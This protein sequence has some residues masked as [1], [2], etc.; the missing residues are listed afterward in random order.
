MIASLAMLMVSCKEQ[1]QPVVDVLPLPQSVELSEGSFNATCAAV[2]YDAKLDEA[3]AVAVADFAAQLSTVTGH[4]RSAKAV[5]DLCCQKKAGFV[6]LY[7]ENVAV[8]AYTLT[9]EPKCVEVVAGSRA[10]YLNAI[11]TIKQLLPVEVYGKERANVAWNMACVKISDEPRFGYRGLHFDCSRHFF[12]LEETKKILDVM[13]IYKLNTLHWHLT[14]D[15]GWRIEI[16]SHPEL[17]E[18][19][20]WRN[21]TVIKKNWNENDGIRY[22]GFYTQEEA[23]E[24]IAYADRLGITVIPEVDLPGHMLGVLAAHPEVGCTGGPYEVWQRWGISPDVL[25]VGKEETFVLLEEILA[26]LADLF[27]SEYFHIGG[28][29]CPKTRWAECPDCQKRIKELGL[30]SDKHATK[31]Q[32]LQ[33]YVTSRV[34]AFLETKG[35]RIIGWDEILEGD[36]APGA[37]VMSWRGVEGGIEAAKRGFDAIM[38]PHTYVYFDYYQSRDMEK[39]PFGIGGHLPLEKVYSYNPT[40][41]LNE[42]QAKHILGVQANVWTEYIATNEHLEYMIL[43]R[44]QA[45]C[46]LQWCPLE[47]RDLGRLKAS[48]ANHQI[49]IFEYLGYN[50][51]PLDEE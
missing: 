47:T 43:P 32:R 23:K 9:V 22:G 21:G 48:I 11:A 13:A 31:E 35:K 42:E 51:R 29:E 50:Y 49:K 19:G 20:A 7:D 5:E 33:N 10:G 18:I 3:S 16:K 27:P 36:L 37:T 17:T 4:K 45:L 8:D 15:Q 6:F 44:M 25:C 24:I 26:E 38:T 30:K 46:E 41:G 28:D 1:A 34:Q 39:E 12:S 14:D 2:K 40:D